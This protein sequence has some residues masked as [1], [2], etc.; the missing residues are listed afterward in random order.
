MGIIC[1]FL[2]QIWPKKTKTIPDNPILKV[3]TEEVPMSINKNVQNFIKVIQA[4]FRIEIVIP[5][6]EALLFHSPAVKLRLN[7]VLNFAG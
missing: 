3:T 6:C 5:K 4:L 1:V 2:L 7:V